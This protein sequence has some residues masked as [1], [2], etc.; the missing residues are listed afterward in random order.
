VYAL[1]KCMSL[2][3]TGYLRDVTGSY[4]A[5][6]H[7]LGAMATIGSVIL[8]F[9][10]RIRARLIREIEIKT[11]VQEDW[12]NKT[13]VLRTLKLLIKIDTFSLFWMSV[14][15]CCSACFVLFYVYVF[16]RANFVM[17]PLNLTCLHCLQHYFFQHLFNLFLEVVN[18][19]LS[20]P[21]MYDQCSTIHVYA[22]FNWSVAC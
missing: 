18:L 10:P 20:S 15:C 7:L 16:V 5:S 17:V 1:V 8:F 12:N 9:L 11:C 13:N 4:V 6:Y 14:A 3:S 19:N 21:F 2:L 22:I